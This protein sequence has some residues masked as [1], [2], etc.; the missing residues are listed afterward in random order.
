MRIL[1]DNIPHE[2]HLDF[3]EKIVDATNA[4]PVH[5]NAAWYEHS[6]PDA[7]GRDISS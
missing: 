2:L 7:V 4:Q 5:F 1:R 3:A 6:Q